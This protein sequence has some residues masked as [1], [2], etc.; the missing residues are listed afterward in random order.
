MGLPITSMVEDICITNLFLLRWVL[1]GFYSYCLLQ[2][3][4]KTKQNQQVYQQLYDHICCPQGF[5]DY[6][7]KEFHAFEKANGKN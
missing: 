1:M 6:V 2:E 7:Y 3:K 4:M 5:M